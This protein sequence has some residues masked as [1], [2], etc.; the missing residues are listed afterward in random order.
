MMLNIDWSPVVRAIRGR[1]IVAPLAL[2]LF[3]F[4]WHAVHGERGLIA[5]V[6]LNHELDRAKAELVTLQAERQGLERRVAGLGKD[7]IDPDLL[8]EELR[9][10]GYVGDRELVIL[11]PDRA[12]DP[13]K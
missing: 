2:S 3:Y 10:L 4:G 1:W 11:T 7:A 13:A 12:A 6:D 9:K 8:E 5:W